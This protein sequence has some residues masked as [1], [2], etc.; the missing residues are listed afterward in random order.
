MILPE[1]AP[2]SREEFHEKLRALPDTRKEILLLL[3]DLVGR[4]VG[5][6]VQEVYVIMLD[7]EGVSRSAQAGGNQLNVVE[8]PL[9][10]E[11]GEDA[12]DGEE[13]PATH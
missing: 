7:M 12:G 11:D 9:T 2:M 8:I 6:Q 4:V 10:D 1:I 13:T 3:G 5:G